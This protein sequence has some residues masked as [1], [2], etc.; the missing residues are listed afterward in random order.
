MY[1]GDAQCETSPAG[2]LGYGGNV[3]MKSV[4]PATLQQRLEHAVKDAE[5]RLAEAK[6]ARDILARNPD[7]EKLLNIMQRGRF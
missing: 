4:G 2:M 3:P 7:L 6:E 1:E 5:Q